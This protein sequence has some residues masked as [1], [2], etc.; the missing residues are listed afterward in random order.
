MWTQF[1]CQGNACSS[2]GFGAYLHSKKNHRY[3]NKVLFYPLSEIILSPASSSF[4]ADTEWVYHYPG[5]KEFLQES[6]RS[7]TIFVYAWVTNSQIEMIRAICQNLVKDLAIQD[8]VVFLL[9][10]FDFT[11][12][13]PRIAG[14]AFQLSIDSISVVPTSSSTFVISKKFGSA[15]RRVVKHMNNKKI[16]IVKI[17]QLDFDKKYSPEFYNKKVRQELVI[18]VGAPYS[19]KALLA[20]KAKRKGYEIF[21]KPYR[22]TY[23]SAALEE[24][25]N[26][27][28][29]GTNPRVEDR[30]KWLKLA[31]DMGIPSRVIVLRAPYWLI[32]SMGKQDKFQDRI[33]NIYS[34]RYVDPGTPETNAGADIEEAFLI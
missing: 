9:D 12:Q 34:A 28:L 4:F 26:V 3:R 13:D 15:E 10:D 11:K 16:P 8:L 24:G 7:S 30:V 6:G 1:E 5:I 18:L 23:I 29:V 21:E 19:G 22:K 25:K 14:N 2:K 17:N 32:R 20:S 27:M 33:L 31:R